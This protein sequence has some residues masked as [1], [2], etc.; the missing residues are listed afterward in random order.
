MTGAL[1]LEAGYLNGEIL[2][3]LD[4]EDDNE[5]GVGCA[6][7]IDITATKTYTPVAVPAG[8]KDSGNTCLEF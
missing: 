5:I 2:L 3:N 7:G 8:S 1:G 6:G 4:T